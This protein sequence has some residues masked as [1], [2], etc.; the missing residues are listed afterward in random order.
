ML[1]E[2]AGVSEGIVVGAPGQRSR[3]RIVVAFI[4]RTASPAKLMRRS[5]R[6]HRALRYDP[7]ATFLIRSS[8][9][10]LQQGPGSRVRR[11]RIT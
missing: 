3:L 7:S 4:I 2:D 8:K 6:T 10:Q 9:I 11:R 1:I 5:A